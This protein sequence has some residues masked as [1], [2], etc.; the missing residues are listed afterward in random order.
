MA[1]AASG[2][3]LLGQDVDI[4]W[5]EAGVVGMRE[6]GMSSAAAVRRP[7]WRRIAGWLPYGTS[8][9]REALLRLILVI[10]AL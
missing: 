3:R 5:A 6:A 9:G 8:S 4:F 1:A 7:G 10:A 2:P